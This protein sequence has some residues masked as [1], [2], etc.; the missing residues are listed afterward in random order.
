M[1]DVGRTTY[2]GMSSVGRQWRREGKHR[3]LA[4]TNDSS[5]RGGVW[6]CF[7]NTV[8][9]TLFIDKTRIISHGYSFDPAPE[10]NTYRGL[11]YEPLIYGGKTS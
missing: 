3:S 5:T 1:F 6:C 2:H 10:I 8:L 7:I 4:M 9:F 11:G